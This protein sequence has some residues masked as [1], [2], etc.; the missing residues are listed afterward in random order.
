MRCL[1]PPSNPSLFHRNKCKLPPAA[2]ETPMTCSLSGLPCLTTDHEHSA[3]S[4]LGHLPFSK[5]GLCTLRMLCYDKPI[6]HLG[7]PFLNK[8]PRASLHA[9]YT[10]E[11]FNTSV[12]M[13][14]GL[15]AC[16]WVAAL[17]HLSLYQYSLLQ[18]NQC[19]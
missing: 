1:L 12:L 14:P 4:P 15:P 18:V 5:Y 6:L 2:V 7:I 17:F 11:D 10:S 19:N 13:N 16:F 3:S 8:Q 9:S